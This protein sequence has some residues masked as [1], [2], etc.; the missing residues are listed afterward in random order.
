MR[1]LIVS[2]GNPLRGDDGVAHRA[3]RLCL[4]AAPDAGVVYRQMHQL[5]P[6]L[7]AELMGVDA[8][9]FVDSDAAHDGPPSLQRLQEGPARPRAAT[10]A[11]TAFEHSYAPDRI[12]SLAR[13][14]YGFQGEAWVC[15]I[16]VAD[17]ELGEPLSG[18]AVQSA[19]VAAVLLVRW[20]LAGRR[21]AT[22]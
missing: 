10:L 3:V 15:R 2:I 7:A 22:P 17:F 19:G 18:M 5:V 14:L 8:V 6:E 13:R 16:P 4:E 21:A 9:V 1:R 12:V 20:V 11:H